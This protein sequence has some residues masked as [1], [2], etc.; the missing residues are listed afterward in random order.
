LVEIGVNFILKGESTC[1]IINRLNEKFDEFTSVVKIAKE[2]KSQRV[3]LSMGTFVRD[4]NKNL[5]FKIFT[6]QQLI[7]F[8]SK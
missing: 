6:R 1:W 5:I 8:S 4:N 3:F 7:D 2:E